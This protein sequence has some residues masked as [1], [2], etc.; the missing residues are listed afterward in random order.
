MVWLVLSK[1][2]KRSY[3]N[4]NIHFVWYS[5]KVLQGKDLACYLFYVFT[6]C[7]RQAWVL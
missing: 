5:K 2:L 3:L 1:L 6:L 7:L 4:S